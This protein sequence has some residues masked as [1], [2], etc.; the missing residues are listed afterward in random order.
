MSTAAYPL[1]SL[2]DIHAMPAAPWW[3]PAPIWYVVAALV[4][5]A[6]LVTIYILYRRRLYRLL[7]L[8]KLNEIYHH[9]QTH[10][11]TNHYLQNANQLLRRTALVT[12]PH[13]LVAALHGREWLKFLDATGRT[14]AFTRGVGRCLSEQ[15]YQKSPDIDIHNVHRT[16]QQWIKRHRQSALPYKSQ[17][18][19]E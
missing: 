8:R 12:Y 16:I 15:A 6:L 13:N 4:L 10:H 11:L 17:H 14:L 2:R 3:P 1:Q 9:F 19:K 5:C 18:R 7:A